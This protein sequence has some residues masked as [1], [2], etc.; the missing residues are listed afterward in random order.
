MVASI[1]IMDDQTFDDESVSSD[2]TENGEETT[3]ITGPSARQEQNLFFKSLSVSLPKP[4]EPQNQEIIDN[5][6]LHRLTK[7][8]KDMTKKESKLGQS[9][10]LAGSTRYLLNTQDFAATIED[11]REYQIELFEKAKKENTIAVLATGTK[12]IRSPMKYMRY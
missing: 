11:P 6:V 5:Q 1:E 7:A 9:T 12:L 3:T 2:N 4:R 10:E 8:A